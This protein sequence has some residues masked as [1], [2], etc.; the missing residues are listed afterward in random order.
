MA[1]R[2]GG[3]EHS[4]SGTGKIQYF[5]GVGVEMSISIVDSSLPA[6]F[7]ADAFAGTFRILE[8]C[9]SRN[10][11][12]AAGLCVVRDGRVLADLGW[13]RTVTGAPVTSD[14]RF[15][16]TCAGKPGTAA[17]VGVLVDDGRLGLDE[18]VDRYLPDFPSDASTRYTVRD[19]LQ[20][21]VRY[22]AGADA[23]DPGQVAAEADD[24]QR[25]LPAVFDGV[26]AGLGSNGQPAYTIWSAN[27]LLA[28]VVEAA[29]GLQ[30]AD[31][32]GKAVLEPLGC[33][34]L[35]AAPAR[36]EVSDEGGDGGAI[37]PLLRRSGTEVGPHPLDGRHAAG[38][39]WPGVSMRGSARD[40]VRL[41][42]PFLPRPDEGDGEQTG[43]SEAGILSRAT[44]AA[45]IDHRA[46]RATRD[47]ELSWGLG[48]AVDRR[49]ATR[50]WSERTY[51]HHGVG[52]SAI[53]CG[54][55][56]SRLLVAMLFD[57]TLGA[58]QAAIRRES[59]LG[60]LRTD[61]VAAGAL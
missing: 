56:E 12:G 28:A 48:L 3:S 50:D 37:A 24:W 14:T 19:L 21:Q 54:D 61:L 5:D 32:L 34:P 8:K 52:G 18:P 41:L 23:G 30:F 27:L 55:P 40:L 9:A 43:G 10:W 13:G 36:D 35:L 33:R 58:M 20:H 59:V 46:V 45:M 11:H 57:T 39:V 6:A 2:Y 22:G 53:A 47:D 25:A 38:R 26:Q 7:G 44:A 4:V 42:A 29:S 60:A 17:A 31:H 51:G 1:F 15:A 49:L 16:W